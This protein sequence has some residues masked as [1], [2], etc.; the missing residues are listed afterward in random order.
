[1][2][3]AIIYCHIMMCIFIGNIK[4]SLLNQT[5]ASKDSIAVFSANPKSLKNSRID[6]NAENTD[7]IIQKF[8]SAFLSYKNKFLND[9]LQQTEE[10]DVYQW[11]NEILKA[12]I[13][14]LFEY[15]RINDKKKTEGI[16]DLKLEL[17]E[18]QEVFETPA[19]ILKKTNIDQT[20]ENLGINLNHFTNAYYMMIYTQIKAMDFTY[21]LIQGVDKLCVCQNCVEF[22]KKMKEDLN[23]SKPP[24]IDD[25]VEEMKK[26]VETQ[27]IVLVELKY[28]F[29][30]DPNILVCKNLCRKSRISSYLLR[31]FIYLDNKL[32]RLPIQRSEIQ[33]VFESVFLDLKVNI[34]L[35][36]YYFCRYLFVK[37][38]L[39]ETNPTESTPDLN[40][41]FEF[42]YIFIMLCKIPGSEQH[43]R[44]F[45][46]AS[47]L[48]EYKYN[49]LS[50]IRF[51]TYK[52]VMDCQFLLFLEKMA[53][54]K[55]D[56]FKA[57]LKEFNNLKS[58]I[59]LF[60]ESF[61]ELA[62]LNPFISE[63]LPKA[64]GRV[65]SDLEDVIEKLANGL[66]NCV[67]KTQLEN[68]F[69]DLIL[70]FLIESFPKEIRST[71]KRYPKI[72]VEKKVFNDL[73]SRLSRSLIDEAVKDCPD[74]VPKCLLDELRK[75]FANLK[76]STCLQAG[77]AKYSGDRSTEPIIKEELSKCLEKILKNI[78]KRVGI[79]QDFEK[80]AS[81]FIRELNDENNKL[82]CSAKREATKEMKD[83]FKVFLD[84]LNDEREKYQELI[85]KF[86]CQVKK[87]F[88]FSI[89]RTKIEEMVILNPFDE[90]IQWGNK[91]M[92]EL[93]IFN[94]N[95]AKSIENKK[96]KSRKK[97]KRK[98]KQQKE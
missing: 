15:L 73:S 10:L 13:T 47:N 8:S 44:H 21:C 93:S 85:M 90:K 71:F 36:N 28:L 63:C 57:V 1:M 96:K 52:A 22:A 29:L 80:K 32:R 20:L 92:E 23:F 37:K 86:R 72:F 95:L 53:Q 68:T 19:Y 7:D 70:D 67:P 25:L 76:P 40:L 65:F 87:I 5:P 54:N 46:F 16:N 59:F 24:K 69:N 77:V 94:K 51:F 64:D 14:F 81:N 6:K 17:E 43:P 18:W 55:T 26:E 35:I 82:P 75:L 83:N 3:I 30:N 56:A 33:E 97:E 42:G 61:E 84:F 12:D 50:S 66:K 41:E 58:N 34:E 78:P 4:S 39:K 98:E 91:L 48:P 79:W 49:F 27:I 9:I 38:Y 2:K 89:N 45:V 31:Q 11:F 88:E 60:P 74:E 62:D